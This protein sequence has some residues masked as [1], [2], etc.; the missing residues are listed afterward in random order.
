MMISASSKRKCLGKTV[1]DLD[2]V[3]HD[4]TL[5]V[6]RA[7][8]VDYDKIQDFRTSEN[9]HLSPEERQALVAAFHRD[10]F[11]QN[12]QFYPGFERIMEVEQ[13]HPTKVW[14][15]SNA[16]TVGGRDGK[17]RSLRKSVPDLPPSQIRLQLIDHSKTTS[18]RFDDDTLILVDDSPYNVAQSPAQL[19]IVP[20]QPWN[21]TP[22]AFT[23]MAGKSVRFVPR[24]DFEAIF[25]AIDD[26]FAIYLPAA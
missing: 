20:I 19:N 16:F 13:K 6:A 18:K 8:G 9:T 23:L 22:K 24:G 21:Q 25:Q 1:F 2:D 14:V 10:D 4:F 12:I 5:R 7:V 15:N 17:F 11:F 3:A 26:F